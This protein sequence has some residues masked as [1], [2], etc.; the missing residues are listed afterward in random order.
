MDRSYV[1][2]KVLADD[3]GSVSGVA[4]KFGQAD[5]IGDWIEPDAFKSVK[6]PIPMLFGHDHNDPI[7]VWD[8]AEIKADELHLHGKLLVE[9]VPRARQ[10]RALVQSGAV[11]GL[12]IGYILKK[13]IRRKGGGRSLRSFELMETSLV[14]IPMHP[15]ARV[16]SAKSAVEALCLAASIQRATAQIATR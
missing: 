14:T 7:G 1:E 5:R 16:T 6:L 11:R 8:E 10:V 15:G 4:W 9:D 13:A 12:S 2:T 3:D